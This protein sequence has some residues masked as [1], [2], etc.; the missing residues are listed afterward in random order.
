LAVP[1]TDDGGGI[2]GDGFGFQYD[3]IAHLAIQ[4][5]RDATV[6]RIVCETHEDALVIF[7]DG[8]VELVSCKAR[9]NSKPY[10]LATLRSDGGLLRLF[11]SWMR[12]GR[13]CRSHLMT[14]GAFAQDARKLVED[15]ESRQTERVG[16]RGADLAPFFSTDAATATEFLMGF[17][18]TDSGT[19]GPRSH[20]GRINASR[21]RAWLRAN[22]LSVALDE[23]CYSLLRDK[24]AECCRAAMSDPLEGT[25]LLEASTRPESASD[26]AKIANRTL[27]AQS[28]NACMR[29]APTGQP[30]LTGNPDGLDHTRMAAKLQR[31]DVPSQV[32]AAAKYLR[33]SWYEYESALSLRAPA[34]EP[35]LTDV[36]ARTLLAVGDATAKLDLKEP[37]GQRMYLAI[38]DAVKVA[39]LG[40]LPVL[41]LSDEL[42][43]GLVFQATDECELFWSSVFDVD[44]ELE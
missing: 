22:S 27:T 2:A 4:M 32:I 28:V 37:Y 10:T 35:G 39:A 24:V 3:C 33:A 12:T 21:L 26:T 36:R 6:A 16:P 31:G 43:L 29:D 19:L 17:R 18:V 42:L 7:A 34:T 14:E 41:G 5:I 9:D 1:A 8:T 25:T 40:E 15:C 44:A 38:R 30:L 13:T 11:D 20:T 23:Q